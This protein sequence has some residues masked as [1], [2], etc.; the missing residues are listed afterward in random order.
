MSAKPSRRMKIFEGKVI[1]SLAFGALRVREHAF[2]GTSS[3]G[4][5]DF[6]SEQDSGIPSEYTGVVPNKLPPNFAII[7][8]FVDTHVHAPQYSFTGTATDLPLMQWLNA[9]TFPTYVSQVLHQ[10]LLREL[11]LVLTLPG[12][13]VLRTRG[14]PNKCTRL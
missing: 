3:S 14:R 11:F 13:Q 9:Y 5:I 4:M 8:G 6:V 2:V 10:P 12:R 1:D 7:P